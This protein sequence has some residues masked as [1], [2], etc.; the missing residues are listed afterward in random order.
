[1]YPRFFL[2][3]FLPDK[4]VIGSYLVFLIEEERLKSFCNEFSVFFLNLEIG[5]QMYIL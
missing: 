5:E 4:G 1:M 3:Q 2:R